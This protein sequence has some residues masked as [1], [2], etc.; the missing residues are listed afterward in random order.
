MDGEV[1]AR[2]W[3]APAQLVCGGE[4]NVSDRLQAAAKTLM[5]DTQLYRALEGRHGMIGLG[6]TVTGEIRLQIGVRP[7][8]TRPLDASGGENR[9]G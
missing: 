7:A 5:A 8:L 2:F 3:F 6:V 9:S 4:A 1:V